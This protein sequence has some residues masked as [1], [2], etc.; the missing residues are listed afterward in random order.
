MAAQKRNAGA[1]SFGSMA[2][3][4]IMCVVGIGLTMASEHTIYIG[5][6]IFG[7]LTFVSGLV[8]AARSRG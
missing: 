2:V 7:A 6:I 3:G 8:G 4:G 1:A 5:L